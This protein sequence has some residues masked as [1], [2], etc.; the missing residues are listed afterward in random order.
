MVAPVV[1]V[2][3]GYKPVIDEVE[4]EGEVM[5]EGEGGAVT[6]ALHMGHERL[7]ADRNH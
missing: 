2:E 3:E 5:S 7:L 4:E 1:A 6:R